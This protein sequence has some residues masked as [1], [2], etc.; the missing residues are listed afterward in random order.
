MAKKILQII[1]AVGWRIMHAQE[2]SEY[3]M[4]LPYSLC[5]VVCWA[6][7]EDEDDNG[8]KYVEGLS[9]TDVPACI[10]EVENNSNFIAYIGPNTNP[11]IYLDNCRKHINKKK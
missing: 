4:W 10:D 2:P 8:F 1:P 5:D 11:E 9:S 3:T 7:V 6:L